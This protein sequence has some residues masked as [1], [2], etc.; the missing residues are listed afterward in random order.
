MYYG[1][2]VEHGGLSNIPVI[3]HNYDDGGSE[4][5]F[6]NYDAAEGSVNSAAAASL[7]TIKGTTGKWA[8]G[9]TD[10][11]SSLPPYLSIYIWRRIA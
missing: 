5:T 8:E 7:K 3:P 6:H 2:I 9:K 11:E 4:W 1:A 10:Y